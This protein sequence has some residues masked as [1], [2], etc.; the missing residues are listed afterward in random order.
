MKELEQIENGSYAD[1]IKQW[2]KKT[3]ETIKERSPI[4]VAV[5]L[6]QMQTA[7]SWNIAE[8]F[9]HEH[10]I[11]ARFMAHPD[12]VTGVTARLIERSKGRPRWKPG[13][14]EQV[15]KEEVDSFFGAPLNLALLN[16]S[17]AA[18]YSEYPHQWIALP[19]EAEIVKFQKD[20]SVNK[21]Q[22]IQHFVERSKGK[23]GVK[24]KVEEVLE[25]LSSS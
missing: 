21:N 8:A 1:N 5:T 13:S 2:A 12:F 4:S 3:A 19:T 17:Q 15:Q 6:R 9:Q 22:V 23:Q 25:R 10:N 11:A 14:L 7:R 18:R 24:E 20:R 16:D